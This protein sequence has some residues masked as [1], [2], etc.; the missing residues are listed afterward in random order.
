MAMVGGNSSRILAIKF[1]LKEKFV[2]NS[3]KHWRL[4]LII[5]HGKLLITA[6]IAIIAFAIIILF[7]FHPI[8]TLFI[9]SMREKAEEKAFSSAVFEVNFPHLLE[10]K[11]FSSFWY[12]IPSVELDE[13]TIE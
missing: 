9:A 10:D 5:D 2:K 11:P 13:N 7:R 8:W 6:H 12:F 3:E 1:N 4:K